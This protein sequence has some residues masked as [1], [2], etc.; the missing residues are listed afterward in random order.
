VIKG[1]L[2]YGGEGNDRLLGSPGVD[3]MVGGRGR[4]VLRGYGAPDLLASFGGRDLID[5]GPG[6]DLIF[7]AD[8]DRDKVLCGP[9]RDLALIDFH[10]KR[11]GCERIRI[12]KSARAKRRPRINRLRTELR[13]WLRKS[14]A[15]RP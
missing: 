11:S 12:R 5:A 2:A 9:A 4:D 3:L 6:R 10:D 14:A 1:G 15:K 8:R 7:T 13:N